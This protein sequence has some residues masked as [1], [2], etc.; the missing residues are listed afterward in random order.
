MLTPN[1]GRDASLTFIGTATTLL[2]LGTFTV[3]TDPNFLHRGQRAYLGYGLWSK[4]R[5]DPA[6]ELDDLP[7]LDAVVLSH[8]HGDHFDRE[9]RRGLSPHVPI[10]TTEHAR[11][12]L[13]RRGFRGVE[14]LRTWS[15]SEWPREQ[16]WLRITAVPAQHG[17]RG[18]HRLLPPTMGSVIDFEENGQRRLRIYITGDTLYR[19]SL[20]EIGT[21]FPDIDVMLIHLG[22]T[23]IG[24]VLLTMNGKQGAALAD[25]IRPAR[26]LPIHYDDYGVFKS[27]LADFERAAADTGLATDVVPWGRG[28]TVTVPFRTQPRAVEHSRPQP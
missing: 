14:G 21:R 26:T 3:L 19:P 27:P 13:R 22:G 16:Q 11:R 23:R 1:S 20:A 18:V 7:R 2:R 12:K 25:L 5:T 6:L 24:G 8:L 4:R 10:V 28:D 15:W 17:P 9:A